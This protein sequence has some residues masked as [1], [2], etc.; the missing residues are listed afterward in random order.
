MTLR[1]WIPSA[2][3]LALS[4]AVL[5]FLSASSPDPRISA[6]VFPPWWSSGQIIAA[7]GAAGSIVRLG[8]FRFIVVV[9]SEGGD[10]AQR[11][12]TSGSLFNLDPLGIA[13]C[14]TR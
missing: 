2:L 11:L 5:P 12:R 8:T 9:R 6:G 1:Q 7:A 10:V 4:T 14:I 3:V 13:G